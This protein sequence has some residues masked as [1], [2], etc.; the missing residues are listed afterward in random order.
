L[1]EMSAPF[2]GM[3][4]LHIIAKFDFVN[5]YWELCQVVLT[6][7]VVWKRAFTMSIETT[8]HLKIQMSILLLSAWLTWKL[9]QR[10]LQNYT[11]RTGT[12]INYL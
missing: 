4:M 9:S 6:T 11:S 5:F 8:C 12:A 10:I 2:Y 7:P 1:E 3:I